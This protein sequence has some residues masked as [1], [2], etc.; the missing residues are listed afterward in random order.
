[1][2]ISKQ[3]VI[4]LKYIKFCPLHLNK[5]GEKREIQL[6]LLVQIWVLSS[7]T[8]WNVD[9][10]LEGWRKNSSELESQHFGPT[11]QGLVRVPHRDT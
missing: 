5:D 9:A 2:C 8:R 3:Q 6:C 10:G 7:P 1:M 4:H 11:A